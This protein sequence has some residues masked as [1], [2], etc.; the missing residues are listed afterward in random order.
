M[1]RRGRFDPC[2]LFGAPGTAGAMRI[3]RVIAR[4]LDILPFALRI[5]SVT[6]PNI[7]TMTREKSRVALTSVF[8]AVLLTGL[9]LTVGL[10]TGSLGILAEALHSGLDLLAALVTYIAVQ[11]ADKPADESHPYGYGK[12]ESLSALIESGLLFLTCGWIIYEAIRRILPGHGVNVEV[13][14]LALGVMVVSIL[15]DFG[16]SRAL[17]HVAQKYSSQ[18]LEADALHFSTDIF[19]SLAVIAGLAL[20][21]W[22]HF[23]LGDPLVA[24][25]VAGFVMLSAIRL[26]I[27]AFEILMDR[28][29]RNDVELVKQG[30]AAVPDLAEFSKLRI[31]RAGNKTFVDLTIKVDPDLPITR[32]HE[33]SENVEREI[34]K[35]VPH[36]DVVVHVEP[37]SHGGTIQVQ[38]GMSDMERTAVRSQIEQILNEHLSQFV[39]FHDVRAEKNGDA[40]MITFHLV[41]PDGAQVRETHDFCDHL[42]QDLQQR[43]DN[44][45]IDIHV[46]PCDRSCPG[47]S[48]ECRFR[49]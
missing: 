35:R 21:K 25:G 23:R 31:R 46:E 19:S 13:N 11:T 10:L 29:H 37:A 5:I 38:P 24:L 6:E 30:I 28:A 27:R 1:L 44:A 9:K 47:C 45:R 2:V 7:Q 41:M 20:V 48:V 22:A 39:N 4:A 16:R 8:A 36:S 14:V 49:T 12:I 40:P 15:V 32:A 43:F 34:A 18:A 3:P 33:V 42:E 17:R 26:T